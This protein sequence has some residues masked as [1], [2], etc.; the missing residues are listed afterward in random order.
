MTSYFDKSTATKTIII[1]YSPYCHE[2]LHKGSRDE[3]LHTHFFFDNSG[4][5]L[6]TSSVMTSPQK[7]LTYTK[8][9]LNFKNGL[10]HHLYRMSRYRL[11][12]KSRCQWMTLKIYLL[13]HFPSSN[14]RYL[15]IITS[16]N[17]IPNASKDFFGKCSQINF[18]NSKN[19]KNRTNETHGI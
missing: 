5:F 17:L 16:T 18:R 13:F 12:I 6:M 19:F 4:Y 8:I 15:K 2:A 11:N 3:G 14:L 7:M 9:N 10:R 1:D